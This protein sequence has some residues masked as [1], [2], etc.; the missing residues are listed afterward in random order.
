MLNAFVAKW[1][2]GEKGLVSGLIL[3]FRPNIT[4][5]P[6][7]P[8]SNMVFSY[9]LQMNRPLSKLYGSVEFGHVGKC[10]CVDD[11][12]IGVEMSGPT[13]MHNGFN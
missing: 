10:G 1:E 5:G 2:G 7:Q 12:W 4:L 11:T 3:Y 13:C 6:I 8:Y 9:L